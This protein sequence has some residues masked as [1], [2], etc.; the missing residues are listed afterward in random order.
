MLDL[1]KQEAERIDS[2]VLEPAC[3]N[4]NFLAAILERRLRV[5]ERRYRKS[6]LEY[7]RN[8]VLALSSLYGIDKLE[9]N[10]MECRQRLFEV[11][12]RLYTAQFKH[13]A[14]EEC[15]E[16]VKYILDRNIVHGDALTLQTVDQEPRPIIFSE[17]ALA[18]GSLIKRKDY[19]FSDLIETDQS[20]LFSAEQY[21]DLGKRAFIPKEIKSYP[22]IHF[23]KVR[24]HDE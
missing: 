13:A 23:L 22:L 16:T 20:S 3:G 10:V 19:I 2:R 7:E 18:T 6:Q 1:I 11:F 9:D 5:V 21:S 15:R 24:Q 4:G 12:D 14:T 17:W 8:A